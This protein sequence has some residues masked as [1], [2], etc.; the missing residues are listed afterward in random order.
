MNSTSVSDF[1]NMD[2]LDLIE[3]CRVCLSHGINMNYLFKY[4]NNKVIDKI[5]FCSGVQLKE[6][7]GL[8]NLICKNC[9]NKLSIAY[10]FKTMCIVSEEVLHQIILKRIKVETPDDTPTKEK[11]FTVDDYGAEDKVDSQELNEIKCEDGDQ[12]GIFP[13]ELNSN[14]HL[15]VRSRWQK[16]KVP[17]REVKSKPENTKPSICGQD[18]KTGPRRLKKFKFARLKCELC[19]IKFTNRKESDDHKKEM[20]S[21]KFN[22]I[23]EVCGKRFLSRSSHCTHARSHRPRRLACAHCDY[24][25]VT[26]SDLEKHLRTHSGIK[27]FKCVSCSAGFH[28]SS[29]LREHE[30]RIHSTAV[31]RFACQLCPKRFHDRTKLNRHIDTHNDCKRFKCEHCLTCFSRRCNWKKHLEKQHSVLVPPQRPGRRPTILE[32]S[33][34]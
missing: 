18:K 23:C 30:R 14:I 16:L 15:E 6:E 29:N 31:R 2:N 24:R 3:I 17:E 8:P 9:L 33:D 10:K 11:S 13:E 28:A 22:W 5:E 19:N 12:D 7:K 32:L 21:E 4:N 26:K 20:H 25:C 34:K 1:S 27:K